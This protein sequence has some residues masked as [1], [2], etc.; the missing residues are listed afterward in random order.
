MST[1]RE[2]PCVINIG[3]LIAPGTRL[4]RLDG[5]GQPRAL[6]LHPRGCSCSNCE[7]ARPARQGAAWYHLRGCT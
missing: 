1:E 2:S 4:W 3:P 7:P 5:S 6:H